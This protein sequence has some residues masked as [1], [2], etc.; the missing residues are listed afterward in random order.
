MAG[1]NK[2][3]V[4]LITRT[5]ILALLL[6]NASGQQEKNSKDKT[7]SAFQRESQKPVLS[8]L[9]VLKCKMMHLALLMILASTSRERNQRNI[10][11]HPKTLPL[12]NLP[13]PA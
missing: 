2:S 7:I 8:S 6:R 4:A 3:I 13:T 5:S 12:S 1:K 11:A 10:I 9:N